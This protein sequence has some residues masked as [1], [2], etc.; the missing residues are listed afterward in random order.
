M[1]ATFCEKGIHFCGGVRGSEKVSTSAIDG[2]AFVD[3]I[4]ELAR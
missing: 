3:G 2:R 1:S 4:V